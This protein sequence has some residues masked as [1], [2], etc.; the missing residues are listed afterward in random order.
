MIGSFSWKLTQELYNYLFT[1]KPRCCRF[2]SRIFSFCPL[3]RVKLK[4]IAVTLCQHPHFVAHTNW[5]AHNPLLTAMLSIAWYHGFIDTN[6]WQVRIKSK[7]TLVDHIIYRSYLRHFFIRIKLFV[8]TAVQHWYDLSK[9][10]SWHCPGNRFVFDIVTI[11]PVHFS[12]KKHIVSGK[13]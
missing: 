9:S 1:K 13:Q 11:F 4:H 6:K 7:T 8:F 5:F 2:S 12:M 10:V 3:L